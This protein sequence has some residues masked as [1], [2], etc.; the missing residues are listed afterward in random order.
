MDWRIVLEGLNDKSLDDPLSRV[1][2]GLGKWHNI[3][4][5][6]KLAFGANGKSVQIPGYVSKTLVS[7]VATQCS[8]I[9]NWYN[10]R[11]LPDPDLGKLVWTVNPSYIPSNQDVAAVTVRFYIYF[12]GNN[13]A[14]QFLDRLDQEPL[15]ENITVTNLT[16]TASKIIDQD[17]NT[18]VVKKL[19]H[20][21][22]SGKVWLNHS[23]VSKLAS[24]TKTQIFNVLDSYEQ[25][26]LIRCQPLLKRFLLGERKYLWV[27]PYFYTLS[28]DIKTVLD[29]VLVNI[30]SKQERIVLYG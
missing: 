11:L 26:G 25:S 7:Q 17:P 19:P 1:S 27:D 14:Q 10:D 9:I 30:I 6:F 5:P 20:G 13:D 3:L 8:D 4:T 16:D 21:K 24:E 23:R 22:Y 18:V 15:F 2:I 12:K 28:D 29:L